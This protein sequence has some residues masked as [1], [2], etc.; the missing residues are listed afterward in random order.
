MGFIFRK[1]LSP[2]VKE[3]RAMKA[4]L[5]ELWQDRL[6]PSGSDIAAIIAGTYTSTGGTGEGE[7]NGVPTQSDIERIIAGTFAS[8]DPPTDEFAIIDIPTESDIAEIIAGE[9]SG[10]FD[11]YSGTVP[12]EDE[13][14]AIIGDEY[15]GEGGGGGEDISEDDISDILDSWDDF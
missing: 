13:I 12:T 3:L 2:I 4:R 5:K 11:E 6:I 7:F 9:Y 15:S 1:P 8:Y 10:Y 14:A